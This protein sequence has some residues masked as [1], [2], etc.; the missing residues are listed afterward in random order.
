MKITFTLKNH[1]SVVK[2]FEPPTKKSNEDILLFL[3]WCEKW[4]YGCKCFLDS[5]I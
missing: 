1:I 2:Y 3:D 5:T 4:L